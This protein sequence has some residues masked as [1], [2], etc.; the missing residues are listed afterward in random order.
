MR[1]GRDEAPHV[2]VSAAR[3][4]SGFAAALDLRPITSLLPEIA[5]VAPAVALDDFILKALGRALVLAGSS[6]STIVWKDGPAQACIVRAD[7]LSPSRIATL[8]A[9]GG[10]SVEGQ[11]IVVTRIHESVRPVSAALDKAAALRLVVAGEG[12]AAEALLVFDEVETDVAVAAR[13]LA[14]LRDCLANPLRLLV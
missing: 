11:A 9:K 8:R 7:E 2:E 10:G 12:D 1:E 4:I 5:K 6:A 14:A 13:L 3:Q